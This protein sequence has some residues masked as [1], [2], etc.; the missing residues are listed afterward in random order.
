MYRDI[1]GKIKH[2]A[3]IMFAIQAVLYA[4]VGIIGLSMNNIAGF[5]ILV[6]GILFAW[7]SSWMMYGFGELIDKVSSI[8]RSCVLEKTPKL[9]LRVLKKQRD[10]GLISEEKYQEQCA[11]ILRN[12]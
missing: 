9:T 6:F 5:F 2:A 8:E 11:E 7:I 1:G 3:Y 10:E 4:A 12:L